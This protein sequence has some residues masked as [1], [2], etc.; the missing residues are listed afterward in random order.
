MFQMGWNLPTSQL[1]AKKCYYILL[2]N[3]N[4]PTVISKTPKTKKTAWEDHD[5]FSSLLM[6]VVFF[7]YL[8]FGEFVTILSHYFASSEYL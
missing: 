5:N 4:Y 3:Y 2:T 7:H 1:V 6:Q 8:M